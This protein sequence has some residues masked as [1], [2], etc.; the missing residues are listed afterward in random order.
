MN[1]FRTEI[2]LNKST[3]K[4]N[5][6][7]SIIT[8][9]SCFSDNIGNRL[10]ENKFEVSTNPFGILYNPISISQNLEK[11]LDKSYFSE[12][13]LINHNGLWH[14][15][16]HHGNFSDQNKQ[17]VLNKINQSI[18][19]QHNFLKKA[20][21]LIITFGSAYVYQYIEK[22]IIIANCHKIPEK[23]FYQYMLDLDFVYNHWIELINKINL[24]NP[25]I[26]IIFTV[27]PIR[28]L[29]YGN[30]MNQISKSLLLLLVHKLKNNFSNIFYFPAYEIFM[31]DLRDYR[32]YKEDM[33]HPSEAGINYVWSKFS[34]LFFDKN[35]IETIK[36]IKEINSALNHRPINPTSDQHKV[37]LN[38]Q[39]NKII[40][41]KKQYPYLNFTDE[42]NY[43]SN[44]N[45]SI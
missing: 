1:N 31:D 8:I 12:N 17:V 6:E 24:F 13:D 15:F 37:F 11:V 14:S 43:F 10:K 4:I 20:K 2:K 39:I 25:Q 41:I 45:L 5:H 16:Y 29:K 21:Y 28:Y 30:E 3:L 33:I 26:N 22:N 34:E 38:S 36:K 23:N 32:F 18:T 27:S 44:S 35:T 42:E 19:S 40:Q 9:G 7:D